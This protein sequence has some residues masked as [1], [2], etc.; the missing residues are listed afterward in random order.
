MTGASFFFFFGAF[1][2]YKT[3]N[4]RPRSYRRSVGL[5]VKRMWDQC[6]RESPIAIDSSDLVTEISSHSTMTQQQDKRRRA[7]ATV[8]TTSSIN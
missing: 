6:L 8:K 1:Y 5:G 4:N 3:C 2:C 7:N